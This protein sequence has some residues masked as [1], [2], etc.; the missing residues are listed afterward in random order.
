MSNTPK[1]NEGKE[2][3]DSQAPVTS[4][5]DASTNQIPGDLLASVNA[6]LQ[7]TMQPRP[8]KKQGTVI[9]S[10]SAAANANSKVQI[11]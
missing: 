9:A 2:I 11:W 1:G 6:K 10:T 7:A 4:E 8:L 3:V 5:A